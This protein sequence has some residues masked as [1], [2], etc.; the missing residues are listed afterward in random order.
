MLVSLLLLPSPRGRQALRTKLICII[1]SFPFFPT[2]VRLIEPLLGLSLLSAPSLANT[3]QARV[4]FPPRFKQLLLRLIATPSPVSC[5]SSSIIGTSRR[6]GGRNEA[7]RD[8]F[9]VAVASDRTGGGVE[10][11]SGRLREKR[12]SG[13][14]GHEGERTHQLLPAHTLDLL[15]LLQ[16]RQQSRQ[17][18]PLPL[19]DDQALPPSLQLLDRCILLSPRRRLQHPPHRV[20]KLPTRR[21]EHPIDVVARRVSGRYVLDDVWV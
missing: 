18:S 6:C 21:I 11:G 5:F 14:G 20:P 7:K 9:G 16:P 13:G 10:N 19:P 3:V 12:I 8:D 2:L 1:R 4:P 17:S 15:H